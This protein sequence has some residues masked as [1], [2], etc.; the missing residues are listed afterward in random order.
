MTLFSKIDLISVSILH[1]PGEEPSYIIALN[2]DNSENKP[3]A[4]AYLKT[5]LHQ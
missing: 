4:E 5:A 3:F 2:F 1:I